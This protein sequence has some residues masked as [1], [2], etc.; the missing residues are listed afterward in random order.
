MQ[1]KTVETTRSS[2]SNKLDED[3]HVDWDFWPIDPNIKY[4]ENSKEV[5]KSLSIDCNAT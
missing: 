2:I 1:G 5:S 3:E 4:D